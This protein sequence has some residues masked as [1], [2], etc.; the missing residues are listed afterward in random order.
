MPKKSSRKVN[1]HVRIRPLMKSECDRNVTE[2]DLKIEPQ[3]TKGSCDLSLTTPKTANDDVEFVEVLGFRV[4][5]SK[6]RREKHYRGFSSVLTEDK[7]N[8]DVFESVVVPL[9]HEAL[10]GKTSCCLAY[11]HTGSGKSHTIFGKGGDLGMYHHATQKLFQDME[12][13]G[14][15]LM[16]QV[17]FVEIY[18]GDAYDLLGGNKKCYVREDGNGNIQIRGETTKDE[19]GT[20]V[21]TFSTVGHA[22]THEELLAFVKAG[23][24]ARTTGNSNVHEH[25]SRSHAILELEIVS[26]EILNLR[27]D[28]EDH[29]SALTSVGYERDSLE[30]E[31]FLRQHE[32]VEGKWVKKPDGRG[33]TSEESKKLVYLGKDIKAAEKKI[34]D[35][36]GVLEEAKNAG[37]SCL[38]GTLV[39]VDLAG[40]EH[41][42][43]TEEGIKKTEKEQKECRE[44]NKALMAVKG[45]FRALSEGRRS[46]SCFRQSKLTLLLRDH[47]RGDGSKTAMISTI[48]PNVDHMMK[49]IHTL[50]Y[51][52]L[53]AQD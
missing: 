37:A 14:N 41:A 11:G 18:N 34:K 5:K 10:Q 30:A 44:I 8:T 43:T 40:S 17:R 27:Q 22:T 51:A 38:G 4:P 36:R 3:N 7:T 21:P 2:L 9:V 29:Q 25:S 24:E 42:G 39:F 48:S 26:Q 47:F 53:V 49:T 20:V 13:M 45:C 19:D 50:Q 15:N 32:K 31:I 23:V 6:P 52:Q 1:V 35:A 16:I 28:I 46:G 12:E 33:S